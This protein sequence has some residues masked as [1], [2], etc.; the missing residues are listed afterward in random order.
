MAR[1]TA[2]RLSA[3]PRAGNKHR[4]P[5]RMPSPI[6]T[7]NCHEAWISQ[8]PRLGQPLDIVVGLRGR[9]TA[10]WDAR[11]RPFPPGARA[12]TVE[13]VR[14][15]A[16]PYGCLIAHSLSDLVEL[17]DVAA[18]RILVLHTSPGHRA[19]Q[20]GRK[21]L[22]A[23]FLEAAARY[24]EEADAEVVAISP[25]KGEAWHMPHTVVRPG[26]EAEQFGPATREVAAGIRVANQIAAKRAT[27]LWDLHERAFRSVP[28]DVVGHNPEMPGVKPAASWDELRRLLARHRFF[29]HTA[30]PKL[31]DG[32][33]LASLEAMAAGL[34]ILGNRHP[35]SPIEHGVSGFL[36]DDPDELRSF[37]LR[38]LNDRALAARMGEAARS[39]VMSQFPPGLFVSGMHAA[40]DRA[41]RRWAA[42]GE[43]LA[44]AR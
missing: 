36:S 25:F 8:L 9:Y 32:Y 4:S 26:I 7:L 19:A 34:P 14:A 11:M 35:T 33:N 27:L 5:E 42:R 41:H 12:V 44:R 24:V 30:D 18:P 20:E 31:E 6:L 37:A 13:Q 2:P 29:V 10:S 38:L 23:G 3:L 43:L 39:A 21:E 16:R 22:P 15:E 1:T 40:I 17:Q 28:V